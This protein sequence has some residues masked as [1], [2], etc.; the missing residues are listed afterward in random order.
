MEYIFRQFLYSF[1]IYIN[2]R[3]AVGLSN[4]EV[5]S[6]PSEATASGVAGKSNCWEN[7]QVFQLSVGI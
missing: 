4:S 7:Y 5:Y 1:D 3:R 2:Y 6:G